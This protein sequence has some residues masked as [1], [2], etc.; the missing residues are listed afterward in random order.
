VN[1]I[2]SLPWTNASDILWSI[3]FIACFGFTSILHVLLTRGHIQAELS[4]PF[5]RSSL[6][7]R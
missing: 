6:T 1:G 5:A 7:P 2:L 3:F 4:T